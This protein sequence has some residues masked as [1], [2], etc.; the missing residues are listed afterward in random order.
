LEHRRAKRMYKRV[1]KGKHI[2]GIGLQVRR[3]RMIHRLQE[4]NKHQLQQLAHAQDDLPT[5]SFEQRETLPPTLPTSHHHISNDTRQKVEL[6][7]WLRDNKKDPAIRVSNIGLA[8]T[9]HKLLNI[10]YKDFLPRLKNHLLSRLLCHSYDGDELD[11]SPS[12]RRNVILVKNTIYRHKVLRVNYT[13]YDLRRAQDSLNPRIQGHGDV[14]VQRMRKKIKNP[15][16]IGTHASLVSI[17]RMLDILVPIPNL[18]SHNILSFSLCGGLDESLH[19]S[20]AGKQ[21]DCFV[22]VLFLEMMKQPLGFWT[23]HR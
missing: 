20:L 15:I 17:M 4:R 9:I 5:V 14:I 18:T 21:S 19:L 23:L 12:D 16:L 2:V 10:S 8:F 13:T 7:L 6:P 11:F 3:E 22:L 1:S